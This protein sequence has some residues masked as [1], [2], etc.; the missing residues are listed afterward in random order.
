M[1]KE[2]FYKKKELGGLTWEHCPSA[3]RTVNPNDIIVDENWNLE[4]KDFWNHHGRSK[5]DYMD[6]VSSGKAD[7][8]KPIEVY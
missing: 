7:N 5:Q 2:G 8:S 4:N 6:Y 1:T 3:E